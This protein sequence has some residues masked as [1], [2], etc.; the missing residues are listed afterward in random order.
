M[1]GETAKARLPVLERRGVRGIGDGQ[2]DAID[3]TAEVAAGGFM[4]FERDDYSFSVGDKVRL[5]PGQQRTGVKPGEIGVVCQIEDYPLMMGPAPRM[6]VQFGD[7]ETA[8]E[9]PTQFERAQ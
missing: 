1:A 5:I 3:I 6:R 4:V 7:R 2:H 9:V 8:W